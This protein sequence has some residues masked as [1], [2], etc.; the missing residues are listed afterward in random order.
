MSWWPLAG[1]G[2]IISVTFEG[3]QQRI[4]GQITEPEQAEATVASGQAD[5]V[6]LA[7]ALKRL[8]QALP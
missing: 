8:K 2:R 1:R 4:H 3:S 7:R 5:A 6:A